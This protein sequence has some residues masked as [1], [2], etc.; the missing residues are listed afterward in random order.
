LSYMTGLPS[1]LRLNNILLCAY[2]ILF[3]PS[4]MNGLSMLWLLWIML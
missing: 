2:C 4:S 1:S 3:N